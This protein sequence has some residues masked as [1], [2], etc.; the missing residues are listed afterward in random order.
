MPD[1]WRIASQL[2]MTA[3][4]QG[5]NV[6]LLYP[7][8]DIDWIKKLHVV[9]NKQVHLTNLA[10]LTISELPAASLDDFEE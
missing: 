3:R 6:D 2:D 4:L 10:L 8:V 7:K 1:I 9:A 5:F